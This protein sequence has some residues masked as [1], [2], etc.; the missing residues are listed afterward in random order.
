MNVLM[1]ILLSVIE[2]GFAVFSIVR[3]T[4]RKQWLTG[5]LVCDAGELELFLLFLLTREVNLGFRFKGLFVILIVRLFITV[6]CYLVKRGRT[7]EPKKTAAKVGSGLIGV[8]MVVDGL[9]PSFLITGY[10]G[11]PTTGQ[12]QVGQ[13]QAILVDSSRVEEFETDGSA[14]EIPVY[15]YYPEDAAGETCPLVLFSHG[16]FGYYQ[17]NSSTYMELASHGY[18]VVSM[19]HPYHSFFTHDTEG[20]LIT[21][22]PGMLQGVQYINSD[23]A[24]EQEIYDL[25]SQWLKLR[26]DDISYVIDSLE[27]AAESG[28]L[29]DSWYLGN[30]D[31]TDILAVTDMINCDKIGV[32]GHSLGG[33]AAVSL[34]RER[35]DVGAV[36]DLDGTMLGEQT[37][38]EN[39]QC[40]INQEPY[41]TPL[42]SFDNDEHHFA[43]IECEQQGI[44]YMNN[45]VL[46]NATDGFCTYIVGTMHMDYTDLP[47][48]SPVLASL[49]G[50]GSLD[51]TE[52]IE[53]MNRIILEFFDC[54]LKGEGEFRVQECYDLSEHGN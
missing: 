46:A 47:L 26:C 36:V 21:V 51:K 8:M 27:A 5:R 54:Y 42:L 19:D 22:N 12:Y 48:F 44:P 34:G 10:E 28:T 31:A 16:A 38:V 29:S 11:L 53:T 13:V 39:N 32:M 40:L 43:K 41:T 20:K 24:T 35:E 25:S 52:C 37:G 9:I 49:L 3:K 18:V 2:I 50:S 45:V 15:F 17:S 23:V 30:V 6:I 7:E 1:L 14:R 4:D 33:A